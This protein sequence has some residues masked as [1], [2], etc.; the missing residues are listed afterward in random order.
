M[1][2]QPTTNWDSRRKEERI[3]DGNIF[4]GQGLKLSKTDERPVSS[5][6]QA[7]HKINEKRYNTHTPCSETVKPQRQ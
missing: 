3:R 4:I 1:K 6:A 2:V 7:L 5:G